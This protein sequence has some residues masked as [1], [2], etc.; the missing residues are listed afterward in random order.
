MQPSE[1]IK[2]KLDI[3]DVIREYIQLKPAGVNFRAPC[4]FHNEKTPSFV[5]SPEKQIWHCFGCGKGGDIFSFI[6]EHEGLNFSEVLR[7][8]AP[9]AGVKLKQYDPKMSSQ[10]NR[11][12]DIVDLSRRFYYQKLVNPVNSEALNYLKNRGITEDV[13]DEWQ[14]G[15]AP[16]SWDDLFLFLK[17]K[18]FREPEIFLSGMVIKKE[19]VNRFYN[20]FRRRIMFPINDINGNPVGF[21]ARII[22]GG[23]EQQDKIGKYINSP[24]TLI[25][26]KS[27]ILFG[28][29]KAKKEI[30]NKNQVIIVEG[31][32]DVITAHQHGFKNVIAQSGTALTREQVGLIKRYTTNLLFALDSDQA[33]QS[34]ISRDD[35]VVKSFDYVETEIKDSFGKTKKYIDPKL[36]YNINIKVIEMPHGKDPDECIKNNKEDWEKA[37]LSAK[38]IM[39]YYFDLVFF[40]VN[41]E[42]IEIRKKVAQKLLLKISE[43]SDMVEKDYWIKVL[44]EKLDTTEAFLREELDV[45]SKNNKKT[46]NYESNNRKIVEQVIPKNRQEILSEFFLSLII[47]F[48]ILS[49]TITDIVHTD[50][51]ADSKYKEVYKNFILY[52]NSIRD[53]FDYKDWKLWIQNKE[54][55]DNNKGDQLEILKLLDKL[56]LLGDENFYNLD[57]EK[58]KAEILRIAKDLKTDYLINR[59]KELEKLII[60]ADKEKDEEQVMELIKDLKTL[61]DEI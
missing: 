20:R 15:Y 36:S 61:N 11:L 46:V 2:S 56:V 28:L 12:L 17:S 10:R 42:S 40:S 21:S 4:P 39:Q 31:Q 1:E 49:E 30:K 43:L 60:Q 13:I 35:M 33:G 37:V 7:V 23:D 18:G 27:K 57:T 8:L 50:Y 44:A 29:D 55:I 3:V 32:M 16:E 6:M 45:I 52:Y 59:K 5:V 26:D 24:Q 51:M 53:K 34:A 19:G 58:A 22:P 41:L 25:Y 48:P 14:I 38:P 54:K 47:K 9:K